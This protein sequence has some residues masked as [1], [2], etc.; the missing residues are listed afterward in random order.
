MASNAATA[1]A[2]ERRWLFFSLAALSILMSAIDNTI[3]AVALPTLIVDLDT[4]LTWAGWTVTAYSLTQTIMMPMAGKL[5]EQFGQMR[6]FLICVML[7]TLGSLLCW[8]AP[9][10]Y[11]LIACRILQAAGGGGFFPSAT[12]IVAQRFP[13]TRS[14]MIGLFATIFPVGGILGPNIGGVIIQNFGWRAVFLVN[15]PIG[16]LVIATL[17][18]E[19]LGPRAERHAVGRSIDFVGAALLGGAILTLMSALTLLGRNPELAQSPIL[20]ATLVFSALLLAVFIRHERRV[21]DPILD[22]DLVAQ[23]PFLAM[24][25]FNI[26][27]GVCFMGFFTFIPFYATVQYGMRPLEAGLVLTPRSLVM[28]VVSTTT[29]FMLSRTGYRAPMLAGLACVVSTLLLLGLGPTE[30]SLGP[31]EVSPLILLILMMA[32][33]GMG[34]GLLIPSSNNAGLDLVPRRTAAISGIR[35]LFNSTGGVIGTALIV[36]WLELSPDKAI[37]LRQVFAALGVLLLAAG[38]LLLLIPDTALERRRR[39]QRAAVAGAEADVAAARDRL[40][41]GAGPTTDR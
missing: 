35:G 17:A 33:S 7:F 37:G 19:A 9:N 25:V 23:H 24:N 21:S 16:L 31:V 6:V 14:R 34:M 13:A 20:W 3:V 38:P 8:F 29:S 41:R 5:A 11:V 4:S 18:R 36:L 12:G 2:E 26:M 28:I 27:A 22:L 15:V 32:L 10:V 30:L 40:A 39:E 1:H